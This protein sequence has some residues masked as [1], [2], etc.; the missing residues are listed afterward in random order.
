MFVTQADLSQV[1]KCLQYFTSQ[2]HYAH[3]KVLNYFINI[4]H[5]RNGYFPEE[6]LCHSSYLFLWWRKLRY[7]TN[8]EWKL[9]NKFKDVIRPVSLNYKIYHHV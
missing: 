1:L 5:N 8:T 2:L 3:P 6:S 4:I 7:D 9:E